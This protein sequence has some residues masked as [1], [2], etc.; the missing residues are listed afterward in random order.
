M[1][2]EVVALRYYRALRDGRADALLSDVA[3]RILADEERHVP[4]HVDR[5]RDGF[6]GSPR[7]TRAAAEVF[8][9]VLMTGAALVVA[10]DHGPALRL[11]GVRRRQFVH[12]VLGLFR[13]IARDVFEARSGRGDR[14]WVRA[15]A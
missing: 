15:G 1:L 7:A 4:F 5:L 10:V 8:W 6:A 2:A 12:D 3:G 11:L 13:P 9:W 14:E